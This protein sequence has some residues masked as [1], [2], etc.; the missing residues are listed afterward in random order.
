MMKALMI[1]FGGICTAAASLTVSAA[2]TDYL[3]IQDP[4]R[5]NN[6]GLDIYSVTAGKVQPLAGSP[7]ALNPFGT[8]QAPL[9]Y[10]ISGQTLYAIFA[11]GGSAGLVSFDL[12]SGTP[13]LISS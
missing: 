2:T 8:D 13:S 6:A 4:D 5:A 10:A 11:D 7:F 3:V 12:H 9:D 1:S